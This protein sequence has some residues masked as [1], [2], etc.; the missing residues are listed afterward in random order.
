MEDFAVRPVVR[1]SR[2]QAG[3]APTFPADHGTVTP[4]RDVVEEIIG[5][6]QINRIARCRSR[7]RPEP[8]IRTDFLRLRCAAA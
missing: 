6:R 5:R 3:I 8:G 1:V 4:R 7:C 2:P